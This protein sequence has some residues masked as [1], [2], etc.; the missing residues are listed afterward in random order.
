LSYRTADGLLALMDRSGIDAAFVSLAGGM[1]RFDAR[2]AN[3]QLALAVAGHPDRLWPVGTLDPTVPTWHEDLEDGLGRLGLAGYRLHPTYQGYSLTHPDVQKL[4]A[5]L[6]NAKCPLFLAHHVDEERY[7]H[8]AIRV[9]EVAVAEL[10]SLIQSAP[11]TTI[12]LNSLKVEH[13]LAL[14]EAGLPLDQVYLDINAM[15]MPFDGLGSLVHTH[16]AGRLV[17]GS[18]M[19]FLYP[20]AALMLVEHAGLSTADADAILEGNWQTDLVLARL[21]SAHQPASLAQAPAPEA[22]GIPE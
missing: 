2:E 19:P 8:P 15:D 16:G 21:V 11:R 7:Q 22:G 5:R 14:L 13:A 6:A 10:A 9:G 17:F 20:E 18:Q 12:V 3:Q 1:F 4:A